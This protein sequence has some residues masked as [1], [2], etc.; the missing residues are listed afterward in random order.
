MEFMKNLKFGAFYFLLVLATFPL[1]GCLFHSGLLF[2]SNVASAFSFKDNRHVATFRI[3]NAGSYILRLYLEESMK[4]DGIVVETY[5]HD[6]KNINGDPVTYE[7]SFYQG[8]KEI[9]GRLKL[10]YLSCE[11]GDVVRFVI[12][13]LPENFFKDKKLAFFRHNTDGVLGLDVPL[14]YI[15]PT[16]RPNEELGEELQEIR[17]KLL[18]KKEMVSELIKKI[19]MP[20]PSSIS[21]SFRKKKIEVSLDGVSLRSRMDLALERALKEIEN[22][23]DEIFASKQAPDNSQTQYYRGVRYRD[24]NGAHFSKLRHAK[25]SM[26]EGM[27]K[28]GFKGADVLREFGEPD[29]V[30]PWFVEAA[31]GRRNN[32]IVWTYYYWLFDDYESGDYPDEEKIEVLFDKA[33]IVQKLNEKTT[34][35]VPHK[36]WEN[37][38]I[39]QVVGDETQMNRLLK[40]KSKFRIGLKSEAILSEYGWPNLRRG[41]KGR[42]KNEAILYYQWFY[43][44]VNARGDKYEICFSI[45]KDGV[46]VNMRDRSSAHLFTEQKK[47]KFAL[48]GYWK[49]IVYPHELGKNEQERIL[50]A[51]S[52]IYPGMEV[53]D[54][55][56]L[57]GKPDAVRSGFLR[58]EQTAA[59]N[60]NLIYYLRAH[61]GRPASYYERN[62]WKIIFE[63]D[64]YGRIVNIINLDSEIW[65]PL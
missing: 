12:S 60:T 14:I 29:E 10:A 8:Q 33:G 25:E 42:I 18:E 38:P 16:V 44:A 58:R 30:A 27:K 6:S 43:K 35:F 48:T 36:D 53:E 50:D 37:E 23:S 22:F 1:M 40:A 21:V 63:I 45:N 24:W 19:N 17:R 47:E 9:G 55:I 62:E 65:P 39:S 49:G 56:R 20:V 11:T 51:L 2:G 5:Q 15:A 31:K 28:Q 59:T 41:W 3:N 4:T 26:K 54:V 13:G 61:A 7:M 64:E 52:S 34:R 57:L 32:G 46:I